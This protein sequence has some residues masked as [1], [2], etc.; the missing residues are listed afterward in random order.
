[1]NNYIDGFTLPIP[2]RH[3]QTY[4]KIAKQIGEIWKEHGALDYQ[5]YV[6]DTEKLEG[7][8]SFAESTNAKEDEAIIFGYVVFPSREVRDI[9]NA[10]VP[11]D[12]RMTA[13]VAPLVD[14]SDPIFDFGRMVYGGF[15]PIF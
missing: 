9:A 8:R 5:E 15:K 3:V 1:M 13:L 14:S 12:P 10:K 4:G 11:E 2:K 6:C 7:T